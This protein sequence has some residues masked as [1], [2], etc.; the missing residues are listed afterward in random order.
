GVTYQDAAR[1][2]KA[3]AIRLFGLPAELRP[4]IVYG[5]R[6]TLY[7]CITNRC[8]NDCYYC[9]RCHDYMVM[10][11][12]LRLDHEPT[13][14]ELLERIDNPLE[15]HEIV[16]SGLGEP[17]LRWDVCLEVARTLRQR[18]ARVRLNTNGQG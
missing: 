4:E 9:E 14:A 1:I 12:F 16:L 2:T 11:H 10:G 5:I 13:A 15:V 8:T 3:N 7:L 17:T 18:G 6:K